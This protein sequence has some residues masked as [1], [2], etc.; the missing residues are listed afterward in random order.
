MSPFVV[1]LAD[2]GLSRPDRR[3]ARGRQIHLDLAREVQHA[4]VKRRVRLGC[5]D[6]DPRPRG[7]ARQHR[8]DRPRLEKGVVVEKE[9]VVEIEQALGVVDAQIARARRPDALRRHDNVHAGKPTPDGLSRTVRGGVIHDHDARATRI[10]AL[11]PVD[12]ALKVSSTIAV[13]HDRYDSVFSSHRD[14]PAIV[15]AKEAF[16]AI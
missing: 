1:V 8:S 7:C 6:P 10:G 3:H 2:V 12:T 11:K 15:K 16:A 14:P 9:V 13:D 4:F 5:D